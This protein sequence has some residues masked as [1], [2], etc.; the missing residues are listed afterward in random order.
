MEQTEVSVRLC[1]SEEE[2]SL[3]VADLASESLAEF[4]FIQSKMKQSLLKLQKALEVA[5]EDYKVLGDENTALCI[6]NQRMNQTIRDAEQLEDELSVMQRLLSEKNEALSDLK[7]YIQKLEKEK[8]SLVEQLETITYEMSSIESARDIETKK[9]DNLTQFHRSLQLHLEEVRLTLALKDE[10]I[11]QKDFANEQLERSLIEYTSIIQDLKERID[12]LKTKQE[13]AIVNEVDYMDFMGSVI[14]GSHNNVS[15]AEEMHLLPLKMGSSS[16]DEEQ[17]AEAVKEKTSLWTHVVGGVKAAAK[18]TLGL[19]VPLGIL[20]ATLP[21]SY[22]YPARSSSM[23]TF[24]S[25][26]GS[27]A[28]PFC[29]T[30]MTPFPV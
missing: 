7:M 21:I 16:D 5:D 15:L 3:I 29:T 28:E 17:P 1:M 18:L 2:D 4:M 8:V 22:D 27:L 20:V 24:W 10:V 13:E 30:Y 12:T 23:D 26:A 25:A 6:Q 11:L 14:A 19:L 9:M